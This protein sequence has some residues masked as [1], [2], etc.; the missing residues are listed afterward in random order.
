MNKD[1][2]SDDA[3]F[4]AFLRGDDAL[5]RALQ[6]MPQAEPSPELDDQ[7]MK[8]V[9]FAHAQRSREAA[10][11][12]Q[13]KSDPALGIGT[14]KRWRVPVGIAASVLAGVFATQ[15][16]ESE[17][18]RRDA[19]M[20]PASEA[21][22]VSEVVAPAPPVE[23]NMP[24]PPPPPPAAP[25]ARGRSAPPPV[26]AVPPAPIHV[27]MAPAAP[28][29]PAPAPAAAAS[30]APEAL[31]RSADRHAAQAMQKV[32]VTGSSIRKAEAESPAGWLDRIADLLG[33]GKNAEALTEWDNFRAA[34][35][36]HPVPDPLR[37]KIKALGR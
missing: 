10:N 1:D 24:T 31:E 29:A 22:L 6:A 23:V 13:V 26:A 20:A 5:S 30:A 3:Q 36:D 14:G 33:A 11:D 28:P 7:I 35:P 25:S 37:A 19:D 12:A 16:L 4:E 2:M 8:R 18:G 15:L 17:R 32:E 27:Q 9:R 34:H 21:V